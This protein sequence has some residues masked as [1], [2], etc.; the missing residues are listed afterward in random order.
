MLRL[1]LL[2][3]R[4]D[5][6]SKRKKIADESFVHP[7]LQVHK[8]DPRVAELVGKYGHLARNFRRKTKR[9]APRKEDVND[10]DV[11]DED[12]NDEDVKPNVEPI[13]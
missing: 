4:C 11:N 8:S 1:I 3:L 10:E 5:T 9:T 6:I 2:T 7:W 13:S 12:V